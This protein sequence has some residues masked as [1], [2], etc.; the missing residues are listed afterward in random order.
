[1]ERVLYA[2]HPNGWEKSVDK[3][4]KDDPKEIEILREKL[5]LGGL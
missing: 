3:S 2:W 5:K 1:M 4:S